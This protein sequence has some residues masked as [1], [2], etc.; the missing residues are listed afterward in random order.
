[1][2]IEFAF[3]GVSELLWM[4]GHGPY[5]WACYAIT[6]AV[7]AGIVVYHHIRRRTF[8]RDLRA[9]QLRNEQ[10]SVEGN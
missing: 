5:V 3:N 4:K 8:F 2:N 10:N 9:R 1:M 7:V 6:F